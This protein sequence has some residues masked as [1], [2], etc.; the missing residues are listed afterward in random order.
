[1][2]TCGERQFTLLWT[3]V[4]FSALMFFGIILL[5]MSYSSL[6]LF[7]FSVYCFSSFG[8]TSGEHSMLPQEMNLEAYDDFLPFLAVFGSRSH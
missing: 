4:R 6:F 2:W 8:S 3:Q 5:E 1:M 7:S